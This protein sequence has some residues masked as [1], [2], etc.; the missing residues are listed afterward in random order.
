M[1]KITLSLTILILPLFSALASHQDLSLFEVSEKSCNS[2][3]YQ[4]ALRNCGP[5]G[6]ILKYGHRE[7]R[8]F[9][10]KEKKGVAP[11]VQA[12]FVKVRFCLQERLAQIPEKIPCSKVKKLSF[13]DHQVCYK[14]TGFCQLKLSHKRKIIRSLRLTSLTPR[15][16]KSGL[17]IISSCRN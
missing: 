7:C 13:Q 11:E 8:R 14:Q 15:S 6:Y 12:W 9:L 17:K 2:Y 10:E 3:L 5:E 1:A 4:E 16:V